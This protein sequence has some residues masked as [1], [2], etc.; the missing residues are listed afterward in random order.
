MND[1]IMYRYITQCKKRALLFEGYKVRPFI[2][3]LVLVERPTS[4]SSTLE[5]KQM[6]P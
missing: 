3:H 6:T 5:L 1:M 2:S 4:L